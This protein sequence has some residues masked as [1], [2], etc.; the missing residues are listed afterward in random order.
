MSILIATR[1]SPLALK[2]TEMVRAWL[3]EKL[4]NDHYEELQLTTQVDERLSWSLEK[5]GGIGL[6]TKELEE[7]LLANKATLAVHSAKDMP[8]TF[9][10]DLC[11]AGYLPRARANDVIVKRSEIESPKRIATSSPRRRAQLALLNNDA[12]WTTLRGNVG[13]RLRKIAE[14]QEAD[15][16]LLAAAGLN[17]LDI[18]S[19]DGLDFIE[20]PIEQMVP[21]PGQAAI[22]IQCREKDLEKYQDLFCEDTKLAVTLEREFLHRLGGGCQTPV[23]A[24]YNGTVF[25][26]YHP[27]I[28]HTTYEFEI[29]SI[30]EIDGVLSAILGDLDLK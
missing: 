5:R 4:P 29:E 14:A 22:A 3:A 25:S 10:D 6:F 23:G 1:K 9:Q 8:T 12:E 13:T 26:I 17:R 19:Y 21:A 28:G 24:H 11:I 15:A 30:L 7:A 20:L 18:Q 16:T 27:Q 2:Q